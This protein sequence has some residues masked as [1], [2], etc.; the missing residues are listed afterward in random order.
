MIPDEHNPSCEAPRRCVPQS[1]RAGRLRHSGAET[2]R[3]R[4][5]L[6]SRSPPFAASHTA[7]HHRRLC[8][9]GGAW[10]VFHRQSGVLCRRRRS[11]EGAPI[12]RSRSDRADAHRRLDSPQ[13]RDLHRQVAGRHA[14]APVAAPALEKSEARRLSIVRFFLV[15]RG[16]AGHTSLIVAPARGGP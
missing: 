1:R 14:A 4:S 15:I 11:A 9:P 3:A 5:V 13:R 7:L 6:E 8:R 16:L 12:K 2:S 10:G